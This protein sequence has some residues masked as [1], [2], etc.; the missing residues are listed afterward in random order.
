MQLKLLISIGNLYH[1]YPWGVE[2]EKWF[3][4]R[5]I[6]GPFSTENEANTYMHELCSESGYFGSVSSMKVVKIETPQAG[7]CI[8]WKD[9]GTLGKPGEFVYGEGGA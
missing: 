6:H 4:Q 9:G 1:G 5:E 3:D 2:V 8:V 7:K